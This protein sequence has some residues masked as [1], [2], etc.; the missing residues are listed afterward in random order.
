MTMTE[1][2]TVTPDKDREAVIFRVPPAFK[3]EVARRA[4]EHDRSLGAEVRSLLRAALAQE[5]EQR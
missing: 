2:I 4:R 1:S 5:E 3:E